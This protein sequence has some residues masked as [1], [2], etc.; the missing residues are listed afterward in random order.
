MPFERLL[1]VTITV[2]IFLVSSQG[3]MD[4]VYLERNG[5]FNPPPPDYVIFMVMGAVLVATLLLCSALYLVRKND[6][7]E[8]M[9]DYNVKDGSSSPS[10][11]DATSNSSS[12]SSN[13]PSHQGGGSRSRGKEGGKSS[14]RGDG[15]Y[16]ALPEDSK[17]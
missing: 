14:S 11:T 16:Q 10:A 15:D 4:L 12:S 9:N 3:R 8:I 7:L 6:V 13:T 5:F 2:Y 1:T 17:A